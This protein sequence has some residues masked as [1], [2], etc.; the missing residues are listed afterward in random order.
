MYHDTEIDNEKSFSFLSCSILS[1]DTTPLSTWTT[2]ASK[3]WERLQ[4][5][6][7]HLS[8]EFASLAD[9]SMQ[10]VSN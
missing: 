1:N 4:K 9:K 6:F 5:G 7:K 2:G 10:A 8:V 3:T